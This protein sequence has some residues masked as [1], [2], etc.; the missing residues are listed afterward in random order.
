MSIS[1][2]KQKFLCIRAHLVMTPAQ[3]NVIQPTM[4]LVYTILARV[5]WVLR[6]WIGIECFWVDVLVGE[7]A[8]DDKR[9]TFALAR[10]IQILMYKPKKIMLTDY[11]PL[12]LGA[13]HTPELT[14]VMH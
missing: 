6:V 3:H 14:K 9:V 7:L 13:E 4:R 10:S 1:D 8:A 5:Q 2:W 12:A 11:I